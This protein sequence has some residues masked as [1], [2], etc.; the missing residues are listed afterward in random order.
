VATMEFSSK[1]RKSIISTIEL[2]DS[3]GIATIAEGIETN[4]EAIG[5][6][7]LGCQL[8]QGYY[9]AKP[10]DEVSTLKWLE[11]WNKSLRLPT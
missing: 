9:F 4:L 10:M 5:L 3:L 6:R 1:S 8:G 11:D 2:A 7:E